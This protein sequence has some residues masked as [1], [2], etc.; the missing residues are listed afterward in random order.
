M[1]AAAIL[2]TV[3]LTITGTLATVGLVSPGTARAD[4]VTASQNLQRDDWD[5]A[6][7]GL[8]TATVQSSRFGQLFAT[9][10]NGQVYAQPLTVGN[11]VLVATEDDWV[12]SVNGSTGAVNW[13]RQLGAPWDAT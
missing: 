12:Y 5:S 9:K 4:E 8:S 3:S 13:S 7:P 11:N 10:V 1:R 6:E 2:A